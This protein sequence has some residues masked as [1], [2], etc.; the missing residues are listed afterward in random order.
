MTS[1]QEHNLG[2]AMLAYERK[3]VQL[4][5]R[6]PCPADRNDRSVP[7][8]SRHHHAVLRFIRDKGTATHWDITGGLDLHPKMSLIYVAALITRGFVR[9]MP[10][11]N[12]RG[13]T[14]YGVIHG[15]EI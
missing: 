11:L 8:L 7:K 15:D 5:R 3:Q 9:A 4:G 12:E 13:E 10:R 6:A 1:E 14:L 2:A